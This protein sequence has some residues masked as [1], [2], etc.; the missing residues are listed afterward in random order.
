M[1][2]DYEQDSETAR[3]R[4][5][6]AQSS[7]GISSRMTLTQ[8]MRLGGCR[9]GT[10][11]SVFLGSEA[12]PC[13]YKFTTPF[14]DE[15][16]SVA[17]SRTPFYAAS[18]WAMLIARID[19]GFPLVCPQC[20]GELKM[21]AFL[22]EADPIQQLLI[23]IGEPAI[24]PRIAP[25]RAPPDWFEADFDQTILDKSEEAD[26]TEPPLCAAAFF[27]PHRRAHSESRLAAV[28]RSRKLSGPLTQGPR[29]AVTSQRSL[30]HIGAPP[31]CAG[32]GC[33]Q[34]K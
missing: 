24:P 21:V 6:G 26:Q 8:A 28:S 18:L 27:G 16:L 30:F 15:D 5:N 7:K 20:G 29:L 34:G 1:L 9:S 13:W 12:C 23:C 25:A 33:R 31:E 17:G 3:W 19:E 2:S 14:A 11:R 32:G 10:S 4:R 22:T